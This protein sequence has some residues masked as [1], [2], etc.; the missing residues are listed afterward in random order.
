MSRVNYLLGNATFWLF[1]LATL[2]VL[3]KLVF[4][5]K[6]LDVL[7]LALIILWR[8]ILK[9]VKYHTDILIASIIVIVF[10]MPVLLV[11]NQPD[12]AGGFAIWIFYLLIIEL[13]LNVRSTFW[14]A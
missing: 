11:V 13:I 14:K 2:G 7:E 4:F 8:Y 6:G 1:V 3:T 5:S 10:L 9:R 12:I